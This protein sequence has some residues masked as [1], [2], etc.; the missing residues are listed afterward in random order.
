MSSPYHPTT[1]QWLTALNVSPGR[2][3][4]TSSVWTAGWM[5]A[6]GDVNGDGRGDVVLYNPATGVWFQCVTV[7]PGV[8]AYSSGSWLPGASLI[9]RPR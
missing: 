5:V 6:T 2:F 9:G 8:F 3:A 1:G 4:V 7:G